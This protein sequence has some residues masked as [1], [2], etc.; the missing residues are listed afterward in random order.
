VKNPK[1]KKC[2]KRME[3][4]TNYD[5]YRIYMCPKCI[6]RY[7]YVRDPFGFWTLYKRF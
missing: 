4:E 3:L 1:C 7:K 6:E 2:G 5:D